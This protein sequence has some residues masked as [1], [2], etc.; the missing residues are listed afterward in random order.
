M[1]NHEQLEY[2]QKRIA[3]GQYRVNS[4]RVASAMLERIGALALDRE[5]SA[6]AGGGRNHRRTSNV[7]RGV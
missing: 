4:Q 3:S 2:V 5:V 1:Q 7:L 6:L